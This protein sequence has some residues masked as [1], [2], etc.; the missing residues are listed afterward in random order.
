MMSAT[1]GLS[2]THGQPCLICDAD[3]AE[4][5]LH[6]YRNLR[7][8]YEARH[9]A[10]TDPDDIGH[11]QVT[12]EQYLEFVAE[13][14]DEIDLRP[15]DAIFESAVGAGWLLRGLRD[16]LPPEVGDTL[17]LA[18][19]DIIPLAIE[20]AQRGL[21]SAAAASPPPVLCLGD[22]SDLTWVPPASFDVVVCGYLENKAVSAGGEEWAGNWVS[23]MA[24]CAKPGGQLV[25]GNNH[26][27]CGGSDPDNNFGPPPSW[28]KAAAE[29]D[30]FGWGIDPASVRAVPL[31]SASLREVWNDRYCV[32]MRRDATPPRAARLLTKDSYWR[33]REWEDASEDA[34]SA[35]RA[36]QSRRARLRR[37]SNNVVRLLEANGGEMLIIEEEEEDRQQDDEEDADQEEEEEE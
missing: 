35:R 22:S 10:S 29:S 14:A 6:D 8:W 7:Q 23:Q 37:L 3:Q 25:V 9:A 15:G 24:W 31:R 21:K 13:V 33:D 19:N 34:S 36:A 26:V 2:A 32:Y 16:V 11:W 18:G 5:V 12:Y 20:I 27:P 28:W 4:K 17:R 30:R 1:D